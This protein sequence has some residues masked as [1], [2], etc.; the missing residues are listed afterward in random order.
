MF[1][2]EGTGWEHLGSRV[3]RT[4]WRAPLKSRVDVRATC[5]P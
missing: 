3:D 1:K 2:K 4:E 5:S